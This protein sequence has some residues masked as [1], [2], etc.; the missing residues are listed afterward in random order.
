VSGEHNNDALQQHP[1]TAGEAFALAFLACLA[2]FIPIDASVFDFGCTWTMY[3]F[4]GS[5]RSRAY[6]AAL[7]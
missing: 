5:S 7:S 1:L 6:R 3:T 4:R 2:N